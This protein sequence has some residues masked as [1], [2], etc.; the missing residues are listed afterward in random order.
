MNRILFK[1]IL[2]IQILV[3]TNCQNNKK[4][5]DDYNFESEYHRNL[6]IEIDSTKPS[7]Q[8]CSYYVNMFINLSDSTEIHNAILYLEN[9]QIFIKPENNN[10]DKFLLFDLTLEEYSKYPIKIKS[11]KGE[12]IFNS[13]F[14]N[15]ILTDI[16]I[17]N[18]YRI[19]NLYSDH[20]W[21][22]SFK[23]DVVFFVSEKY[24]IIGTYLTDENSEGIK[25]II[26]P[27]GNI[28]EEYIDYTKFERGKIL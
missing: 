25:I 7:S 2:L 24:G 12:Y 10:F 14:E 28:L 1:F 13:I 3:F 21:K 16:G 9:K 5:F 15:K 27:A 11:K 22:T 26:S 23:C 4:C 6:F 19:E 20:F 8:G 17:V 18:Q